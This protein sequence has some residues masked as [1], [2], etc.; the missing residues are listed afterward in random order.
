MVLKYNTNLILHLYSMAIGKYKFPFSLFGLMDVGVSALVVDSLIGKHNQI[1]QLQKNVCEDLAKQKFKVLP[2][3]RFKMKALQAFFG[4][5]FA[6][7]LIS[8][9]YGLHRFSQKVQ[10]ILDIQ[11]T[12]YNYLQIATISLT[13]WITTIS[14]TLFYCAFCKHFNAMFKSINQKVGNLGKLLLPVSPEVLKNSSECAGEKRTNFKNCRKADDSSIFPASASFLAADSDQFEITLSLPAVDK[15]KKPDMSDRRF[16]CSIL[17]S[18]TLAR[19]PSQKSVKGKCNSLEQ[20]MVQSSSLLAREIQKLN[21]K[22]ASVSLLVQEADDLFSL[23]VLAILAITFIRTCCFIY[24]YLSSD[25]PKYDCCATLYIAEQMFFDFLAFGSIAM[26]ASLVKEEAQKFSS[27]IINIDEI[28]RT[29]S[30]KVQAQTDVAQLT[31]YAFD[32]Q[33]TAWK[34]FTVSRS[35]IPT[36]IGVTAT[37]ILVI[38][39]LHQI[40]QDRQCD[41]LRNTTAMNFQNETQELSF[42]Y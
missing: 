22:F 29:K 33:L 41:L 34:F 6:V 24:I 19:Y 7:L 9:F 11:L 25:W 28:C 12:G 31:V 17:G 42:Y 18:N 36:V 30:M 39:Q 20:N 3:D 1:I 10:Q 35:F 23:Q 40:V 5:F 8:L 14:N 37:Y 16:S 32:V 13:S 4:I 26:E 38:F 27:L 15:T 2:S 21:Q